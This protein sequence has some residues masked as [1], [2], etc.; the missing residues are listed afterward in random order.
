MIG[1]M[2][3]FVPRFT[4]RF[5]IMTCTVSAIAAASGCS[6][7][8]DTPC[9]PGP[10]TV[11][12]YHEFGQAEEGVYAGPAMVTA[13][14]PAAD[15]ATLSLLFDTGETINL[16]YAIGPH[17][18]PVAAGAQVE[19]YVD[20]KMPFWSETSLVLR[21]PGPTGALLAA[22]WDTSGTVPPAEELGQLTV[23]YVDAGCGATN[24]GCGD[25]VTLALEVPLGEE[26]AP[27]RVEA[28]NEVVDGLRMGNGNTSRRFLGQ[29]ACT[30][31][32]TDWTAGYLL[33]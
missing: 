18:I 24:D 7:A 4:L 16:N 12:L 29:I 28:G 14:D 32:P 23:S 27:I 3:P 1:V 15:P 6:G 13:H 26:E 8:N 31:T 33:P 2:A 30:D 17:E 20:L 11:S 21:E 19:A 9:D 10:L 5:C 25:R 22:V